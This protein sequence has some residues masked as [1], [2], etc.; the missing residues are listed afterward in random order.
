[1]SNDLPLGRFVWYD[2]VTTDPEGAV[3]FYTKVTGWGTEL[4]ECGPEPYTMWSN[5]DKPIGGVV[6]LPAEAREAGAPPHWTAYVCVEDV[7]STAE[8]AAELGGS[9][10]HPT[11]DIP[12]IGR[13]AIIADPQ[14]ATIAIYTPSGE[15]PETQ[16]QPKVGEVSWHEL[17]TSD[18]VAAFAFYSELFGW[19]KTEAMDMGDAGIYQM[20]GGGAETLGGMYD[21]PPVMPVSAWLYYVMV[22]D[23]DA[24]IAV[25][26]ANGGTL[27]NGPMEVPGGS[28]VAQLTDP[29]GAMFALHMEGAAAP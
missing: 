22:P 13:F 20:Y 17:A 14:G 29:Q 18:H 10:I 27:V 4:S 21:K 23:I 6:E 3:A 8:R 2:L 7:D 9:L 11:T 28:M 1:M 19:E 25:A 24:A 5:D 26:T 12:T 15:I 16:G